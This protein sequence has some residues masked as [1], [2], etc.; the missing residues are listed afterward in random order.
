MRDKLHRREQEYKQQQ[1]QQQQQPSSSSQQPRRGNV[2]RKREHVEEEVEE[3]AVRTTKLRGEDTKRGGEEGE[4]LPY[5][6]QRFLEKVQKHNH[7][8][9]SCSSSA[10]LEAI[11]E[12]VF[13]KLLSPIGRA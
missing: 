3:E 11:E 8:E 6:A 5:S 2:K 13:R 12:L 1:Q 9:S 4:Q 7:K 10:A